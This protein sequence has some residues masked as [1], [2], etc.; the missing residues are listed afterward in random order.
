MFSSFLNQNRTGHF[1][2][3]CKHCMNKPPAYHQRALPYKNEGAKA[4]NAN[5]PVKR[6]VPPQDPSVRDFSPVVQLGVTHTDN[7]LPLDVFLKIQLKR[8]TNRKG[9]MIIRQTPFLKGIFRVNSP[10]CHGA[11]FSEKTLWIN[12]NLNPNRTGHFGSTCKHCTNKTLHIKRALPLQQKPK[13]I[14]PPHKSQLCLRRP[15]Q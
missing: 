6:A 13:P 15:H 1:G 5:A 9:Q 3:T 11:L 14:T 2:S 10:Q 12:I 4:E 7:V 8:Q